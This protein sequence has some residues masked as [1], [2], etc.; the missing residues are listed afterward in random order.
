MTILRAR[1]GARN[2]LV[3]EE[4]SPFGYCLFLRYHLRMDAPRAS[5]MSGLSAPDE[6]RRLRALEAAFDP[7]TLRLL[8]KIGVAPGWRCAEVA[9]GTGSIALALQ[10]RA[11]FVTAVDSDTQFIRHLESPSFSTIESPV[12]EAEL[13]ADLDLV[14]ARFLLDLVRDPRPVIEKLKS[15]LRP[16]GWLFLEEFDDLTIEASM[17]SD[18]AMSLHRVVLDAK[19]AAWAVRGL[20]SF[21]GRQLPDFFISIGLVEI[22]SECG[23][24]VRQSGSPGSFGWRQS[25]LGM[26]DELCGGGLLSADEFDE[27]ILQLDT[28][29]FSYFS[30]LVVRAFG[31]VPS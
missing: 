4:D 20:D 11:G 24:R 13:P 28:P 5:P 3:S 9:A 19:Q 12:E 25:L 14:H 17:G 8:D 21:L 15:T 27:Y 22:D 30:P 29:G 31:R 6:Y 18:H 7:P 16:G 2:D 23:C 26:R 1:I 10:L